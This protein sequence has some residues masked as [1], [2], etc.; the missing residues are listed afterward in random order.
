MRLNFLLGV[1]LFLTLLALSLGCSVDVDTHPV[2]VKVRPPHLPKAPADNPSARIAR[3]GLDTTIPRG[4]ES[5]A[6]CLI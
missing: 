1:L 2:R 6:S 3:Y 5:V 4:V